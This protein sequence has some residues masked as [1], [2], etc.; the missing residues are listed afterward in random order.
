MERNFGVGRRPGL[1]DRVARA[2]G[3]TR[4]TPKSER[5]P[6]QDACRSGPKQIHPKILRKPLPCGRWSGIFSQTPVRHL[7][8]PPR[9]PVAPER[10][11]RMVQG[12]RGAT[13]DNGTKRLSSH[14]PEGAMTDGFGHLTGRHAGSL[15]VC[16]GGGGVSPDEVAGVGGPGE[17]GGHEGPAGSGASREEARPNVR[18]HVRLDRSAASIGT[19][20]CIPQRLHAGPGLGTAS[21][22]AGGAGEPRPGGRGDLGRRESAPEVPARG[23]ARGALVAGADARRVRAERARACASFGDGRGGRGV[24]F[25]A[26]LGPGQGA[27]ARF[28]RRSADRRAVGRVPSNL[29]ARVGAGASGLGASGRCGPVERR[30][31]DRNPPDIRGAGVRRRFVA[32]VARRGNGGILP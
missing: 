32:G 21:R 22:R 11:Q 24:G 29:G 4:N 31:E 3:S 15:A 27:R 2:D 19:R 14:G 5:K 1:G 16:A 12:R 8:G 9:R 30:V 26:D 18:L 10:D 6:P 23:P 17:G 7:G 13:S 25:G 20:G 28:S